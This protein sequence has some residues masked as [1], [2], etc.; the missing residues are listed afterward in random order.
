[1]ILGRPMAKAINDHGGDA[2]IVHLPEL[3]IH[4]NTHFSFADLNNIQIADL[5]SQW[6][7]ENGL[8]ARHTKDCSTESSAGIG[9]GSG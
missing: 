3:G 9:I 7:K 5:L 2:T 8:D 6:L 4:G 1:M